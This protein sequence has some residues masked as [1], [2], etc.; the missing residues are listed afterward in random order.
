ML[1]KF[2]T[3]SLVVCV[4]GLSAC[5]TNSPEYSEPPTG[6]YQSYDDNKLNPEGYEGD[7]F[8]QTSYE[9]KEVVVPENYFVGPSHAPTSHKD[10]DREWVSQQSAQNYTIELATGD[11]PSDVANTLY[12][13]P[14]NQRTAQ[15]RMQQNGTESYKG[16]YGSFPNQEAA[17]EALGALPPNIKQ[18]AK[19]QTWGTVQNGG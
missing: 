3:L 10:M 17:Q 14:K 2:K 9:K 13:A 11:K 12:Q 15:I 7:S 5:A 8:A 6:S 19:I 4:S 1:N 18:N 16:F